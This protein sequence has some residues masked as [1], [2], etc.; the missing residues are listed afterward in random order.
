MLPA[1]LL[2]V[3]CVGVLCMGIYAA[4]PNSN[5]IT[6][7]ITVNSAN[8]EVH[9]EC[10]VDGV[11][12]K[13][14]TTRT[15]DKWTISGLNFITQSANTIY[16]VEDIEI[17]LRITNNSSRPLGAYFSEEAKTTNATGEDIMTHST[18]NGV[19]DLSNTQ[20]ASA[21]FKSYS[22]IAPSE[23]GLQTK[24]G[25][26][27]YD[28][29]FVLRCEYI[30]DV[31]TS[32]ETFDYYLNI[33]EYQPNCEASQIAYTNS[34]GSSSLSGLVKLPNDE[35]YTSLC[36]NAFMN[37]AAV[38][39][40]VV[41]TNVRTIGQSAFRSMSLF[42][43]CLL[44]NSIQSVGGELFK[45]CNNLVSFFFP[46]LAKLSTYTF[47]ECEKLE[48][49]RIPNTVEII[50]YQA[51]GGCTN[52]KRI[53][54]SRNLKTVY[55]G[56]FIESGLYQIY[57]PDSVE[58][59]GGWTFQSC[60]ALLS[61]RL[62]ENNEF[63]RLCPGLFYNCASLKNIN[64]PENVK[65]T[66]ENSFWLSGIETVTFNDIEIIGD[67]T[68]LGCANLRA[69]KINDGALEIG[70][71]AFNGS[72]LTTISIPNSITHLASTAFE[73]CNNLRYNIYKKGKYIGNNN[74]PYMALIGTTESSVQDFEFNANCKFLMKNCFSG[75]VYF[76][77]VL[78]PDGILNLTVNLSSNVTYASQI[79]GAISD[80]TFLYLPTKTNLNKV[81]IGTTSASTAKEITISENAEILAEGAFYK[82][83][84]TSVAIP[85]NIKILNEWVFSNCSKLTAVNLEG[86]EKM[87]YG[88]FMGCASLTSITIPNTCT[89]IGTYSFYGTALTSITIP[90]SVKYLSD[91]AFYGLTT[92]KTVTID[93]GEIYKESYEVD[94][95]GYLIS[96]ATTVR[97]LKSVVDSTYNDY[98]TDTT[99]YTKTTDGD[100]YV[101]TKV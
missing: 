3:L 33:E 92:L 2:L 40:I 37:N 77:N 39:H 83:A 59:I 51:F 87:R 53:D 22:Y 99:R 82:R 43:G 90:S 66:G 76:S 6:G 7:S 41:P 64:I 26:D 48:Y 101:F 47:D 16:D 11:S 49:I 100:Y 95:A 24:S 32:S 50:G 52:L 81:I 57:F 30:D 20:L 1:M 5:Q 65:R 25:Y 72:S 80:E 10:L 28:M 29:I 75:N 70:E 9:I 13:E 67:E 61:V 84:I 12:K 17:T 69:V 55:G 54:L 44:P 98:L 78:L 94:A 85:G 93:S 27:T 18:I 74:N 62:P 79:Y 46:N 45:D 60:G 34:V 21:Y 71:G 15:G 19:G 97:V 68:F 31:E 8:P 58:Y 88:A 35:S 42:E 96:N 23:K 38:T 63:D 14:F 89:D 56:A 73:G 91:G 86:I 36:D 4:T